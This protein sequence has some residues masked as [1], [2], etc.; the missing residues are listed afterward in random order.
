MICL[1]TEVPLSWSTVSIS[2]STSQ[3]LNA[4]FARSFR[5][6][7]TEFLVCN[8]W[9][10]RMKWY[11]VIFIY[12]LSASVSKLNVLLSF[13]QIYIYTFF[14]I[15]H[16]TSIENFY[17]CQLLKIWNF[18]KYHSFLYW[19]WRSFRETKEKIF[20]NYIYIYIK[21]GNDKIKYYTNIEYQYY[22]CSTVQL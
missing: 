16:K 8:S 17:N 15:N 4:Q 13:L 19:E 22:K 2:V 20:F 12:V 10:R 6:T 18:Q 7:T 21:E 5:E 11:L 14:W 3:S 9:L 1:S